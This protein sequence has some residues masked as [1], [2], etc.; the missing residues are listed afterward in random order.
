MRY[1]YVCVTLPDE[2]ANVDQGVAFDDYRENPEAFEVCLSMK[3]CSSSY[4]KT[5]DEEPS[6]V[7]NWTKTKKEE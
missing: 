4:G 3:S 7:M 6:A 2:Y 1:M 5:F